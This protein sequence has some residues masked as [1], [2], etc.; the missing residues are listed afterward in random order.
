[1]GF[2]VGAQLAVPG[3]CSEELRPRDLGAQTPTAVA[4]AG[5]A[6]EPL[7][8]VHL[9]GLQPHEVPATAEELASRVTAAGGTCT[10]AR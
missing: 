5:P 3:Q 6:E 8:R 1:M 2:D 10:M 7:H 9:R 4:Q